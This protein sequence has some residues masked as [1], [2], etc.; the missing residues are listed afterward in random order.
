MCFF[1]IYDDLVNFQI[2]GK[3]I[4]F[5]L[6]NTGYVKGFSSFPTVKIFISVASLFIIVCEMKVTWDVWE[7]S[8]IIVLG[9]KCGKKCSILV[10]VLWPICIGKAGNGI[11]LEFV[12]SGDGK[13]VMSV[14]TLVIDLLCNQQIY[15]TCKIQQENGQRR[16]IFACSASFCFLFLT[17][18]LEWC[19]LLWPFG[20]CSPHFINCCCCCCCCCCHRSVDDSCC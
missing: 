5:K 19:T 16:W 13:S 6:H 3:V 20:D 15:N 17:P 2:F 11:I 1:G 7:L 10:H 9:Y 4:K 18:F 14:E 12:I 8:C